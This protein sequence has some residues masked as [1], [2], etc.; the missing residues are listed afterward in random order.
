MDRHARK[1]L[2]LALGL[3]FGLGLMA[4][5]VLWSLG[6]APTLTDDQIVTRAR[7]LGMTRV[8]ELPGAKVTLVVRADTTLADLAGMLKAAG[9]VPDADAFVARVQSKY[10][11]GKP[12]PGLHVIT[13]GDPPDVL[14]AAL[15]SQP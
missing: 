9:A 7:A 6:A 1:G 3:G 13:A 15:V 4:G 10:P 2:T 11:T 14:A 12:K 8:T 5:A